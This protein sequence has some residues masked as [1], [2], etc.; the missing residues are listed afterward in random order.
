MLERGQR[1]GHFGLP[2][3]RERAS[4]IS[5]Q[6]EFASRPTRGASLNLVVPARSAYASRAVPWWQSLFRSAT[7]AE[8]MQ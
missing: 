6:L 2:G 3:M 1:D 8:S 4:A 5:G 7:A